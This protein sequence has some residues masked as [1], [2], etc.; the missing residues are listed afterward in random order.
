MESLDSPFTTAEVMKTFLKLKKN[1]SP[2]LDLLPPEVFI[3]SSDLLCEPICKLLNCIFHS[4]TY[5]LSWSKGTIVPV[6]KKGG[7]SDVNNFRGITLTSIFS[8]LYLHY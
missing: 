4:N 1:K 8:K 6:P 3:D 5:P 7:L 2:R